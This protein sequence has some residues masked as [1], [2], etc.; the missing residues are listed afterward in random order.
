MMAPTSYLVLLINV[1]LCHGGSLP[2]LVYT[3]DHCSKTYLVQDAVVFKNSFFADTNCTITIKPKRG[4]ITVASFY[5]YKQSNAGTVIAS[6]IQN[7]RCQEYLKLTNTDEN[8]QLLGSNGYCATEKPT[9]QYKLGSTGVFQYHRDS[10]WS[11]R[12]LSYDLLVSEVF[13]KQNSADNCTAGTFDC[14]SQKY[15]VSDE[16]K[17]NIYDDCGNREDETV[18]CTGSFIG[19][20]PVLMLFLAVRCLRSVTL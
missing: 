19:Y 1:A 16:V 8:D 15:C 13:L 7:G 14:Q 3:G 20:S 5:T 10:S 4:N 11:A 12:Y 6:I 17:C 9:K 2:K 18:G